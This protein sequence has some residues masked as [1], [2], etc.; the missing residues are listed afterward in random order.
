MVPVCSTLSRCWAG[1]EGACFW[2]FLFLFSSS[3]ESLSKACLRHFFL[4]TSLS[5]ESLQGGPCFGHFFF[6][7]LLTLAEELSHKAFVGCFFFLSTTTSSSSQSLL[8]RLPGDCWERD[9]A[10]RVLNVARSWRRLEPWKKTRDEKGV[11]MGEAGEQERRDG[12]LVQIL[13]EA[14]GFFQV[15]LTS[16]L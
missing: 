1:F 12:D 14:S 6:L 16:M 10:S 15:N 13:A 8:G 3:A 9:A 11:R 7:F 5:S 4:S 2:P